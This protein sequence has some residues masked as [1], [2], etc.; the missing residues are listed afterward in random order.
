MLLKTV[1]IRFYKS[2]NYD[3][4]KFSEYHYGKINKK[5]WEKINQ[6]LWYPYVEI[7]ID[8]QITTVVGANES[9]KSHLLSAI[10]KGIT[11]IDFEG[12]EIQRQDF[13]RYSELFTAQQ[14]KMMYPDFGFEYTNLDVKDK[15]I[16][17]KNCNTSKENL[18]FTNFLIFRNN[19]N[20]IR[21]Y[22]PNKKEVDLDHDDFLEFSI[23][24]N[25][26]SNLLKLLPQPFEINS[27]TALPDSVPIIRLIEESGVST[28]ELPKEITTY[29]GKLE[30]QK[31]TEI[32]QLI[33]D[34][35]A[36][37]KKKGN[38]KNASSSAKSDSTKPPEALNKIYK[39]FLPQS[40]NLSEKRQAEIQLAYK[41]ICNVAK[42]DPKALIELAASMLT[43]NEGFTRA[44]TEQINK[45]L[46]ENLNF[47]NWWVQDQNFQLVIS[48]KDYDIGFA[49]KDRTGSEYSFQ[50]RSS[51]LK[52]FLSY[53]IQYKSHIS[54]PNVSEIL[55]MDEPD[56]YLSSQAQQN[57]LKIFQ[58]FANPEDDRNPIQVI[59][60]T[61][62]PFLIDKN[63][64]E[65][66]RVLEKGVNDEGTRVVNDAAK[67]HYEPL[68]SAFGA[69]VGETS[70]IG[71]CNLLVE[72]I[73]TQILISGLATYLR[74]LSA[75]PPEETLDLNNITIIPTDG[76][77]NMLA[78]AYLA[79][80]RDI[81]RPAMIALMSSNDIAEA[82]KV[83]LVRTHH[84]KAFLNNEFILQI[85]DLYS[86]FKGIN[87]EKIIEI[88]DIIPISIC[89]EAVKA[90]LQEV[91][92]LSEFNYKTIS[93]YVDGEIRKGATVFSAIQ[94]ALFLEHSEHS[95]DRVG[96]ARSIIDFIQGISQEQMENHP[97]KSDIKILIENFKVLF[98]K[99]NDLQKKALDILSLE[100][101]SQKLSRLV[102]HFLDNNP[103]KT[104]RST[105]NYFLKEI[106]QKLDNSKESEEIRTKIQ[107][108]RSEFQL[109]YELNKVV[110]NYKIFRN[111]LDFLKYIPKISVQVIPKAEKDNENNE[112]QSIGAE[113]I[114]VE[115][116]IQSEPTSN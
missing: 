49:I 90:Y 95:I 45:S 105:A 41:L 53:Y 56:Q 13:C 101:V 74:S 35:I 4:L 29:F 111:K 46:A 37:E 28:K 97:H 61:H 79:R 44:I 64:P 82:S 87:S 3:Y 113:N 73:S 23:A 70:F 38:Q 50:E 75:I 18:H 33:D 80:G 27:K 72:N 112:T 78:I 59:Y 109:E 66:V 43:E 94:D 81:E 58:A 2:F 84:K 71:N 106:E 39:E 103:N 60:V 98:I 7:P 96:F 85:G 36:Q 12:T 76:S 40:E 83:R 47:P 22:I 32:T 93:E 68:R 31:R 63:Y 10:A 115:E 69:F 116:L 1:F 52:Y 9:G 20:D 19:S 92:G 17:V 51:G 21:V 107:Q 24:H 5:P 6:E 100:S 91:Y 102:K 110:D 67:H 89:L 54:Q 8:A 26:V 62:S 104:K 25:K 77:S 114:S 99:L 65:R 14:D 48:P 30:R 55:L 15:D 11:G 86:E 42:I 88:E 16:I 34:W 57:L 108:I